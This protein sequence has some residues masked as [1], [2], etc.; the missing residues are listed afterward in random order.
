MLAASLLKVHMIP[1][2]THW[3]I[4][5]PAD[6][7]HGN[8]TEETVRWLQPTVDAFDLSQSGSDL[9]GVFHVPKY[10]VTD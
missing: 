1:L 10:K 3:S 2:S 8:G 4:N 9:F 6:V 5:L 7:H